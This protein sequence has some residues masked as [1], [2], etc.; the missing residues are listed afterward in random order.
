M[1]VRYESLLWKSGGFVMELWVVCW[2]LKGESNL[3]EQCK[4]YPLQPEVS[5]SKSVKKLHGGDVPK[6]DRQT[7]GRMDWII[8]GA[9]S[10]KIYSIIKIHHII[11]IW[12]WGTYYFLKSPCDLHPASFT[13][14]SL[15]HVSYSEHFNHL[16]DCFEY[17]CLPPTP[18]DSNWWW[19][20][21]YPAQ[22]VLRI[23]TK[24]I[25][26]WFYFILHVYIFNL[27]INSFF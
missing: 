14:H 7:L 9:N 16:L 5:I 25:I 18:L 1:K 11:G 27:F 2:Y 17:A 3:V 23:E 13:F 8:L 12:H 22:I 19:I 24:H 4:E 26:P 15:H 10:V 21:I 20:A 6:T